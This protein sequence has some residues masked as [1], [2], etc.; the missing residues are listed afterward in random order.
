[1]N[2]KFN[3]FQIPVLKLAIIFVG[4]EKFNEIVNNKWCLMNFIRELQNINKIGDKATTTIVV[5][6]R[7]FLLLLKWVI[8][9]IQNKQNKLNQFTIDENTLMLHRKYIRGV[10]FFFYHI[11]ICLSLKMNLTFLFI[12][13]LYNLSAENIVYYTFAKF[14]LLLI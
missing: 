4:K 5:Y 1:M 2:I 10:N 3:L 7:L 14:Y 8:L 6:Q 9:C 13:K 12:Y 11:H